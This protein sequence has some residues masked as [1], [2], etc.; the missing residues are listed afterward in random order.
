MGGWP[1]GFDVI[2]KLRYRR[3][4]YTRDEGKSKRLTIAPVNDDAGVSIHGGR[5]KRTNGAYVTFIPFPRFCSLPCLKS[6]VLHLQTFLIRLETATFLIWCFAL[7][8]QL[9]LL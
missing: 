8:Q 7:T 4:G 6:K 5:V 3:I 1:A 2:Q 9:F